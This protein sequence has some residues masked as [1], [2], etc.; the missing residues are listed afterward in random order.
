[1][2]FSVMAFASGINEG[3]AS[4][5]PRVAG[6]G[7]PCSDQA[8]HGDRPQENREQI[9]QRIAYEPVGPSMVDIDEENNVGQHDHGS[10]DDPGQDERHA[11]TP[12]FAEALANS[13]LRPTGQIHPDRVPSMDFFNFT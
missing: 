12:L 8:K 11:V 3:R 4:S 13:V 7:K 6:G 2:S 5:A 1:M 10:D 9:D